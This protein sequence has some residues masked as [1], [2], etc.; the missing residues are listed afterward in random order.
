M[1]KTWQEIWSLYFPESPVSNRETVE[2]MHFA[3]STLSG[4]ATTAMLG[5]KGKPYTGRGLSWLKETLVRELD[6]TAAGA[7][8]R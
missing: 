2:L 5:P 1:L 7:G 3:V 4:L 8:A 6:A